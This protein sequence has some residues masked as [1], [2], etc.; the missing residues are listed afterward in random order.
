MPD[1]EHK[2]KTTMS[3]ECPLPLGSP[4]EI[5]LGHGG[6]GRLSQQL[7]D[8]IFIPAFSNP[9][10]KAAHDG[11]VITPTAGALAFSTDSHV[12]RPFEF[13]GGNIGSLAIHGTANDLAM[14]GAK[15]R[16]MSAGFI[17][18]E[19]LPIDKL[20][21]IVAS[22]RHAAEEVGIQ[23][24]TGDTKV[25]ERGKGDSIYINTAGI[26][27]MRALSP[28]GPASVC[29]GDAI[30]LSGDIGRHGMAIM[31][32][33]EGLEFETTIE[34]DSA[35]LWPAVE[36]LIQDGLN[37]HCLRDLTRG[38]LAAAVHEISTTAK[39]EI[40]LDEK[41][42]PVDEAV[43]GACELLGLDALHV[44]NEGRFIVILPEEEAEK[45]LEILKKEAPGGVNAAI[46]GKVGAAGQGTV[47]LKSLIGVDRVLDRPSGEQLPRIC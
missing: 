31:A 5:Q 34:S 15:P 23:I 14:C 41:A 38:G 17:L 29:E 11:A 36:A 21:K 1:E 42:I 8:T 2:E 39:M 28:V 30:L 47:L 40:L 20:R 9:E 4:K 10:L 7:I 35:H 46:I 6:G 24:V 18:E 37:L 33:R 45:A 43:L 22:M 27:E 12:V 26:G 44:A 16:W 13:P 19:G 32:H 25:V 3:F